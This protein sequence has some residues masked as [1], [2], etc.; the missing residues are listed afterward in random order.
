[1]DEHIKK[2]AKSLYLSGKFD[3]VATEKVCCFN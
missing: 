1:M 3:I 2:P